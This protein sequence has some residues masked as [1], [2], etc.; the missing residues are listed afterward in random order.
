MPGSVLPSG[1]SCESRNGLCTSVY[2][3]PQSLKGQDRARRATSG[4]R[5]EYPSSPASQTAISSGQDE[6]CLGIC[7]LEDAEVKGVKSWL[8]VEV[9]CQSPT[10][11]LRE[12]VLGYGSACI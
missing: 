2:N 3:L 10:V 7:L 12:T 5:E 6:A 1:F 11:M 4:H 8:T 9:K